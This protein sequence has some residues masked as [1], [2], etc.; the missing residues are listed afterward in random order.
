MQAQAGGQLQINSDYPQDRSRSIHEIR[1]FCT[2]EPVND[3]IL[4]VLARAYLFRAMEAQDG[5][6]SHP[7]EPGG[8]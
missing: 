2:L 5:N 6:G 3:G 1:K 7:H 4:V 8:M